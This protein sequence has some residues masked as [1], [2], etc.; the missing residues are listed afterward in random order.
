[1]MKLVPFERSDVIFLFCF[2]FVCLF[3]VSMIPNGVIIYN[4]IIWVSAGKTFL[5]K[6]M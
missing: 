6:S 5:F 1:M 4:D 2:N 3:T